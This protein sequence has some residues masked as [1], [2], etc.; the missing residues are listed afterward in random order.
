M[1]YFKAFITL[2]KEKLDKFRNSE[3]E[4][5][6]SDK[7]VSMDFHNISNTKQLLEKKTDIK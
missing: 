1:S 7:Y 6:E 5:T 4:R 2:L 3:F